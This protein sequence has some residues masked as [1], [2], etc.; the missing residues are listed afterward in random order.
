[1]SVEEEDVGGGRAR[2]K[3]SLTS[4]A[5]MLDLPTPSSPQ[6]AM[7]TVAA[8]RSA[9]QVAASR[10]SGQRVVLVVI[11]GLWFFRAISCHACSLA[12]E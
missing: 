6:T 3:T 12:R 1:M 8:M 5:M 2:T 9:V 11:G 4:E 10:W 7:R